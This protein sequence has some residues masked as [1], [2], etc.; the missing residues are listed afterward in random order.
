MLETIFLVYYLL[1]IYLFLNLYK[2]VKE[3]S[4]FS[5]LNS[6]NGNTTDIIINNCTNIQSAE[7]CK[8]FSETIR[9]LSY[10]KGKKNREF[11][12][13]LAGIIDGD[14]NFDVRKKDNKFK[15]KAI[16]IKLHNRDIRILTR[17]QNYLHLGRIRSD[18]KKPHSIYIVSTKED[19]KFIIRGLNGLIRIK[20]PDFKLACEDLNVKYIKADYTIKQYDP[21]FAG[22]IDSDGSIVYNYS[23]NRIEC[24]LEMKK[25]D[26][27]K[28]LNLDYVIPNCK[29]YILDR[30]H[31]N[32]DKVY[33]SRAFK[34]QNVNT[35]VCVYDF[36]MKNRLYS[37][38]KFYR[39][40]KIKPF[41]E[42]RDFKNSPTDSLEY[43][44][45]SQ[46]ILDW[47]QYKNPLWY[48]LSYIDKIR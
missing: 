2:D 41:L 48:K 15:L 46:F 35:M 19:M 45:Y 24:N 22:L 9:Q 34:F 27:V 43:K 8:G 36:F 31:K 47:V 17:I 32:T 38:L 29:P 7:N 4:F 11:F 42:I 26:Y 30:T 33:F 39:V 5:F 13:W 12:M 28:L 25:N 18:K 10:N 14:G 3:N 44:K 23:A 20:V 16:R 37:D 21:Y 1:F 40:S 6:K